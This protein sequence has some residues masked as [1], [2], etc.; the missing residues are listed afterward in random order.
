MPIH[1]HWVEENDVTGRIIEFHAVGNYAMP[2][3]TLLNNTLL[4]VIVAAPETPLHLMFDSTQLTR[5]GF[6]A[7]DLFKGNLV[8]FSKA[9]NMGVMVAYGLSPAVKHFGEVIASVIRNVSKRSIH[10]VSTREDALA[11]IRKG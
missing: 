10:I 6:S 1:H 4:E 7:I 3:A 11:L 5:I 2:E 8:E 9:P